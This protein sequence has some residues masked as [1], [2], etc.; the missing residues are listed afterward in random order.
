LPHRGSPNAKKFN[1]RPAFQDIL[2]IRS[3]ISQLFLK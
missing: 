1:S 2:P 3:M